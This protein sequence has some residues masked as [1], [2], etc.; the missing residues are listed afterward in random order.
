MDKQLIKTVV[1]MRKL[2]KEYFKTRSSLTLQAA[3]QAEKDVDQMLAKHI[4]DSDNNQGN[5]FQ[6]KGGQ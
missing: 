4:G 3:K 2:Q 5:L 6:Q 1:K